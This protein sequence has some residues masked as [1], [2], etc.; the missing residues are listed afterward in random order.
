PHGASLVS[1]CL[2]L[3]H[4][5]L[6]PR[7]PEHLPDSQRVC[8]RDYR[9]VMVWNDGTRWCGCV[10]LCASAC[11]FVCMCVCLKEQRGWVGVCTGVTVDYHNIWS[12]RKDSPSFL[13]VVLD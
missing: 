9:C 12:H 6:Q 11:M 4:R 3:N 8:V 13:W 1:P 7:S 2:C 10:G 5:L